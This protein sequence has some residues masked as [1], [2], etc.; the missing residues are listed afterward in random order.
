M[1]SGLCGK[2]VFSSVIRC[3]D[4][5]DANEE[6]A[7]KIVRTND[8]MRKAGEKEAEILRKLNSADKENKKHIVKMLRVFDHRKHLCIVFEALS[9]NLRSVLKT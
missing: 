1:L 2:G 3:I 8:L 4:T 7:I 9:L 6:V 5:E